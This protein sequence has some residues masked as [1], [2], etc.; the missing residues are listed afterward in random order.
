MGKLPGPCPCAEPQALQKGRTLLPGIHNLD[1]Q[2]LPLQVTVPKALFLYP[3]TSPKFYSV[4]KMPH[5]LKFRSTFLKIIH[6]L[7]ISYE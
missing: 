1:E 3:A 4:L 6:S 5:M 2:A 7:I